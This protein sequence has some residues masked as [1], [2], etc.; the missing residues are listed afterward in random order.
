MST[1]TIKT[2]A[3]ALLCAMVIGCVGLAAAP[4]TA[5]EASESTGIIVIGPDGDFNSVADFLARTAGYG[6]PLTIAPAE[7]TCNGMNCDGYFNSSSGGAISGNCN[8]SAPGDMCEVVTPVYLPDNATISS[9]YAIIRDNESSSASP[10]IYFWMKRVNRLDGTNDTMS[11]LVS[12]GAST[13]VR[14]I[15]DTDVQY[16]V[17]D[18]PDYSYYVAMRLQSTQHQIYGVLIYYGT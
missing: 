13:N 6:N 16:P 4:A 7:F 10:D 9:V 12:S 18:Y 3:K 11:Y 15:Y 17:I 14:V 8:A 2:L 5:D 1:H